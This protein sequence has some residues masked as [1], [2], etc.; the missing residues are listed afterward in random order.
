MG[1]KWVGQPR[2]QSL[3]R[4]PCRIGWGWIRGHGHVNELHH[5]GTE[6]VAEFRWG[7]A[8]GGFNGR[9]YG[10]I[11]CFIEPRL[12]VDVMRIANNDYHEM[13]KRSL[14]QGGAP[15]YPPSAN[16][17]TSTSLDTPRTTST[18][19]PT[20]FTTPTLPHADGAKWHHRSRSKHSHQI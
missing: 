6:N 20:P 18:S 2:H 14:L 1:K 11:S 9:R 8:L 5:T 19:L 10:T 7:H 16:G 4:S 13:V 15:S 17:T 12:F 3:Y